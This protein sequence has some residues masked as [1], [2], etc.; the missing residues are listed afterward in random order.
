VNSQKKKCGSEGLFVLA[1]FSTDQ[2]PKIEKKMTII[3]ELGFRKL[4]S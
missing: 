4:E 2:K 3:V 1:F